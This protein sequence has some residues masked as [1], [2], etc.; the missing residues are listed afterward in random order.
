MSRSTIYRLVNEGE[1]VLIKI[2]KVQR[3]HRSQSTCAR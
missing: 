1:L 3:H 2:G